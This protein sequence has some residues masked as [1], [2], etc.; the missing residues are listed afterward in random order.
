MSD[1]LVKAGDDT[2]RMD[3]HE[4]VAYLLQRLGP[5]LTAYIAG[6]KSRAMPARWA[7]PP[8]DST[9]ATPSIDKTR[10]LK[11]AHTVFVLIEKA[12][13]DQVARSWL[14]S[15]NPRLDG[16][17]PAELLRNDQAPEVFRAA[18]AFVSDTYYA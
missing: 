5:T 10:R 3:T 2:A 15:A 9:H 18:D 1:L 14:I 13:N 4:V 17:T 11:A 16:S 7:A 6:S 12:E 8:G